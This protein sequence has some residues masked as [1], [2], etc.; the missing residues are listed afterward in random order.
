MIKSWSHQLLINYILTIYQKF[1]KIGQKTPFPA[2]L[3]TPNSGRRNDGKMIQKASVVC[4]SGQRT[5][6]RL[7]HVN[8]E[9][10]FIAATSEISSYKTTNCMNSTNANSLD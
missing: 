8:Y 6:A 4:P 1:V 9:F 7:K 5:E 2:D 3:E 10:N